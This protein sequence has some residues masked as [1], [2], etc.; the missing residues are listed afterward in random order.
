MADNITIKDAAGNN[1]VVATQDLGG[2]HYQ[3][4]AHYDPATFYAFFDRIAPAANKYMATLFN[5]SATR[6]AKIQQIWRLNHQVAAVVG[7]TLEQYLAFITARTAGT[8]V[9]IRPYDSANTLSSGIAADHNSTVVT[10]RDIVQRL[11]AVSEE[12]SALGTQ[13][14][15]DFMAMDRNFQLIWERTKQTQGFVLRANEGVTIRNVTSSTVG[16]V[17]YFFELTDEPA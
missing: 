17:S 6:V 7:V 8:S 2:V 12:G 11:A 3:R 1:V 10:E 14:G 9:T 5:T 4:T 15:E 13:L 16:T